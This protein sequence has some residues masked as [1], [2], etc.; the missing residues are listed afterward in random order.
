MAKVLK[1]DVV[2]STKGVDSDLK[3]LEEKFKQTDNKLQGAGGKIAKKTAKEKAKTEVSEAQDA[4]D[5]RVKLEEKVWNE[6]VKLTKK[7]ARMQV[8]FETKAA[9][10]A[11]RAKERAQKQSYDKLS[12]F[13][14]GGMIG[15]A[16][17]G[18]AKG[19]GSVALGGL[20]GGGMGLVAGGALAG[21]AALMG[22]GVA[23]VKDELTAGLSERQLAN[24]VAAMPDE[25]RTRKEIT[26]EVGQTARDLSKTYGINRMES[27][28]L[29]TGF[30]EKGG[31]LL[32]KEEA[33]TYAGMAM[34]SGTDMREMGRMAGLV[35]QQLSQ[36]GISGPQL[37]DQTK[38]IVQ[39]LIKSGNVG[40]IDPAE[41][42][43]Q[44]GKVLQATRAQSGGSAQMG[45]LMAG[46]QRTGLDAATATTSMVAFQGQAYAKANELKNTYGVDVKDKT[47]KLK[48]IETVKT[49][50]LKATKGDLTKI[51]GLF[52]ETGS[53]YITSE[54]S[55]FKD[56]YNQAKDKKMSDKNAADYAAN[57]MKEVFASQKININ[58]NELNSDIANVLDDPATQLKASFEEMK[59]VLSKEL[60][61]L[62]P[63]VTNVFKDLIPAVSLFTKMLGIISSQDKITAAE[64]VIGEI[65]K[66]NIKD[67]NEGNK[68]GNI[69][70]ENGLSESQNKILNERIKERENLINMIKNSALPEQDKTKFLGEEETKLEGLKQ[71]KNI[72]ENPGLIKDVLESGKKL[73]YSDFMKY[74]SDVGSED[75]MGTKTSAEL[76]NET[77]RPGGAMPGGL[78]APLNDTFGLAADK[79][80]KPAN[81]LE[82]AAQKISDAADKLAKI[83]PNHTGL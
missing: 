75:F 8:A 17:A 53:K 40:N 44:M 56:F 12:K 5:K 43:S 16:G 37:S 55:S 78:S 20:I 61:P 13:L 68:I 65:G 82:I 63:T 45:D 74:Y 27:G 7:Y 34:S 52:G 67:I 23:G 30:Q 15:K 70:G 11:A 62:I 9:K 71:F 2:I 38:L 51:M 35:G 47:G 77:Q 29:L 1:Y 59:Q 80:D 6:K 72:S 79:L 22:L 33:K 64:T 83:P 3:K 18:I 36:E 14:G 26:N 28:A 73:N 69:T 41:M 49:D 39:G 4:A 46:L 54:A 21:G 60:I 57:K 19:T 24:K 32:G 66:Q 42:A 48:D 81:K 76:I 25:K 50:I 58:A 31:K 10:D